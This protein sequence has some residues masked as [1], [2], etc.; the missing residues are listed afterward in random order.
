MKTNTLKK[1]IRKLEEKGYIKYA[2]NRSGITNVAIDY[3]GNYK[4]IPEE[5]ETA[6]EEVEE[7]INPTTEKQ[8]STAIR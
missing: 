4:S 8:Y 3:T 2:S 5:F 6:E 1:Y 7:M